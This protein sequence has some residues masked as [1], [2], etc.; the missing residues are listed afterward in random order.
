[1]EE[2]DERSR[3]MDLGFDLSLRQT[4]KLV[5]TPELQQALKILQFSAV[6]LNQYVQNEMEQNPLLEIKEDGVEGIRPE[7]S[8]LLQREEPVDWKEYFKDNNSYYDND[9]QNAV[10]QMDER[11]YSYENMIPQKTSLQ[12]YLLFQLDVMDIPELDKKIGTFIIESLDD[13]GYL[14]LSKH[15]I[16]EILNVPRDKITKI[17]KIIQGFDPPGVGARSL[18]ECLLI[19]LKQRGEVSAV[20]KNVVLEH[21]K[22]LA[23]NRY[24]YI[25]KRLGIAVEEAQRIGDLIKTLEPK[26]GRRFGASQVRYILPDVI[27]EKVS[28]HYVVLVNDAA[29][30]RLKISEYYRK[31]LD[32][33][34]DEAISQY[35]SEKLQAATWLIKS[36]EQRRR[37][38][39]KVV[40]AI[41]KHQI[42][43]LEK[44][45]LYL[46]PMNLKK[47]A[48]GIDVHESTVS[49]AINGKY[50]QT[51]R[52]TFEIKYFFSSG[53]V[54]M[55]GEGISSESVKRRIK[56]IIENEDN[57][58]P[59]SDKKITD[60]LRQDAIDI[61]RRTVAKYR[62]EMNIPSSQKRKRY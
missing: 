6:E 39:E 25:A 19:Q 41:V 48:E 20:V 22:D 46:K 60:I 54:D 56:E 5:I 3:Y 50:V 51:P 9:T 62:E 31:L 1:M 16:A 8:Y 14:S 59:F 44:G 15:E 40:K 55:D 21:L 57:R 27:I 12:E 23:S 2:A 10:Y 7:G 28:N 17:L 37:T 26:P 33:S 29:A 42:D 34:G 18:R 43:F 35:L 58:K 30:P 36:I 4:Q 45:V 52:G 11:D 24:T 53:V 61:S 49:R 38:L 13:N 47:I 32:A